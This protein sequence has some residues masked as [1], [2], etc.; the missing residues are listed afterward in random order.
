MLPKGWTSEA[1][2]RLLCPNLAAYRGQSTCRRV[3]LS[4]RLFA[5][6]GDARKQLRLLWY[7]MESDII[8]FCKQ[9]L[10]FRV[11]RTISIPN[12]PT[13]GPRQRSGAPSGLLVLG[14]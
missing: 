9:S 6:A 10:E 2:S 12:R 13:H 11:S 5:A 7:C 14:G 3:G 8:S 4:I 1:M